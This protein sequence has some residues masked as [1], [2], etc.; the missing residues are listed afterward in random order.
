MENLRLRS[1][2]RLCNNWEGRVGGR[3]LIARPNFKKCNVLDGNLV[4]IELRKSHI[5]MNRPIVTGMVILELSKILMYEF[6]YKYLKPKYG[7][8]VQ[9]VYTDTDSFILE[10]KT[11]DVYADIRNK[12]DIDMFD[13]WDYPVDNIFGI[14]RHNNKT[15]GKFKDELK[16]VIAT[17][18]VGLRSKCYALRSMNKDVKKNVMKRAKGVKKN[19]LKNTVSFEDYYNCI[20]ENCI[21]IRKQYSIRSKNHNVYTISMQKIALNPFDDKRCLIKPDCID[22][23]AWGHYKIDAET[24]AS[25]YQYANNIAQCMKNLKR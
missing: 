25:E 5:L 3:N 14:K 4:S 11:V 23:L 8:N 24:M 12:P 9:V 22:S 10:V 21:E 6:L 1:D 19:V 13:T 2:I 17:E 20:K 15:I 16:G 7:K 18:V